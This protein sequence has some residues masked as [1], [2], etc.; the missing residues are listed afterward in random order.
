MRPALCIVLF[1]IG[2]SEVVL[3]RPPPPTPAEPPERALDLWG[4]PPSD[5]QS[6][7]PGFRGLYFNLHGHD[8]IERP[9]ADLD[10][11]DSP[12]L[13]QD[14]DWW[15]GPLVFERYDAST[16]FGPS[17]WP[18]DQNF[19][20]DPYYYAVRWIGWVRVTRRGDHDI[21][22]GAASDAWVML[23]DTVIAE[24]SDRE[25]FSTETLRINLNTGVYKLDVRYVYRLG[26]AS[27]F[28]LRFAT[29]GLV[30]C[31]PEYGDPIP[32]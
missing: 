24:V 27:G 14:L 17:W 20:D 4:T 28:R 1:L 29:N 8:D 9:L 18:V 21:V 6:C 26:S 5:W 7:F 11:E 2:C 16:D 30:T 12:T 13:P 3:R 25:S 19:V 31:Y 22:L 32:D 23:N 15:D 10:L